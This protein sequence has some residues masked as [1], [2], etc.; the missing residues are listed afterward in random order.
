MN[1]SV[2]RRQ[3]T[4]LFFFFFSSLPYGCTRTSLRVG[5]GVRDGG[6]ETSDTLG[7]SDEPEVQR[8]RISSRNPVF[9]TERVG[10]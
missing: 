6:P 4:N 7:D 1:Q 9:G 2:K 5:G 10:T 3:K 8:P